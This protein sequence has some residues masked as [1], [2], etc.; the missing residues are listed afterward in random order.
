MTGG[1]K[2][3][4]KKIIENIFNKTTRS[5]QIHE[6][7]LFVENTKGDF[8]M[9]CNYGG[10]NAHSPFFIASISKLF[11]TACILILQERKKISL[12]DYI[13][14]YFDETTLKGLHFHKGKDYSLTLKIADLLFQTSGLP[15]WLKESDTIKSFVE[16]DFEFPFEVAIEKTKKMRP[17]FAPNT[18]NKAHYSE[19]NFNLLVKIIEKLAQMPLAKVYQE[20]IFNP[21]GMVNTY[22]L[23][24]S[25]D[26]LPNIYYKNQSLHRPKFILSNNIDAVSTA[27]DLMCF[28]KAFWGGEIFP[29]SVFEKLSVHRKL[30]IAFGPIHYGGGYMQIPLNSIHTLFMGKGE[31]IG[32]SGISGSFA[33]YYPNKDLF[34][35]GDINQMAISRIP[36]SLVMR[37]AMSIK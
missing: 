9:N 3:Q 24:S 22:L 15:D 19:M 1:K 2:M 11:V 23:K 12:D 27:T 17:H 5:K 6:A 18:G 26:F 28:L 13:A 37:L 29:Q 16:N 30:Q 14:E 34:F 4:N 33:F 20:Y 7:V 36:I 21:L 35:V 8:S 10:K 25:N 31:L 32:H